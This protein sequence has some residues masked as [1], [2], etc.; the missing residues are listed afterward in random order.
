[1]QPIVYARP[2][3]LKAA[4][5]LVL[6]IL[7]LF[8]GFTIVPPILGFV[9]GLAALKSELTGRGAAIAGIILN[10]LVL[11][12]LVGGVLFAVLMLV[13]AI[14]GQKTSTSSP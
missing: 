1:M 12:A 3:R 14:A 4:W 6:G 2:A 7:S 11:L 8:I 10:G 13:L 5:S 9:L